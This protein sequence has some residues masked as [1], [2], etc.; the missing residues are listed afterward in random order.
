[1]AAC[2]NLLTLECDDRVMEC[3]HTKIELSSKDENLRNLAAFAEEGHRLRSD[4]VLW[5]EM[6]QIWP[7]SIKHDHQMMIA[8][9]FYPAISIYLSGVYDHD[10]IWEAYGITTPSLPQKEVQQNVGKILDRTA[11]ALNETNV[12]ALVFLFPLRIA[13]A[14]VKTVEQQ[15]K[16]RALLTQISSS[17]SVANAI[18]SD[19]GEV[20]E[21]AAP[22]IG[23]AA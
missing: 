18:S 21:S 6:A 22:K 4:L 23:V 1:M 20:W 14:R 9:I 11:S 16:I 2:D 8:W 17:F 5:E 12:T 13:G 15:E 10:Q 7:N 3:T 19:L